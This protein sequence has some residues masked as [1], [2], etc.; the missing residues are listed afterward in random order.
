M[1]VGEAPASTAG[2]GFAAR[3]RKHA[4]RRDSDRA[5]PKGL[6][7]GVVLVQAAQLGRRVERMAVH[8]EYGQAENRRR[9]FRRLAL[10]RP[11][12]ALPLPRRETG[13]GDAPGRHAGHPVHRELV[14]VVGGGEN[15]PDALRRRLPDAFRVG[16]D[17]TEQAELARRA[18]ESPGLALRIDATGADARCG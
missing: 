18:R 2:A 6:D 8:G 10:Q 3:L 7:R 16:S 4:Q 17:H 14:G 11:E 9:F 1:R 13:V 5:G 12:Q 15:L